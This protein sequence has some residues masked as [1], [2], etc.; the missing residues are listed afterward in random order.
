MVA[1]GGDERCFGGPVFLMLRVAL[2]SSE[3]CTNQIKHENTGKN[4]RRN[5]LTNRNEKMNQSA[6]I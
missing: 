2:K 3:V 4:F 6:L 1:A 5:V